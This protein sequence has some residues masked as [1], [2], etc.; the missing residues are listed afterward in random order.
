MC[1]QVVPFVELERVF[2]A[3]S[4]LV[5]FLVP[6]SLVMITVIVPLS[7]FFRFICSSPFNAFSTG[8]FKIKDKANK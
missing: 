8:S 6:S 5:L 2:F 4:V 1:L 7:A 3:K